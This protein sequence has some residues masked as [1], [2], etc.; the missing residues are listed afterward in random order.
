M[1]NNAKYFCSF[2]GSKWRA[3]R[4]NLCSTA[5]CCLKTL[6]TKG[7]DTAVQR[8]DI[9]AREVLITRLLMIG[10]VAC[11]C[12][13][14]SY[15]WWLAPRNTAHYGWSRVNRAMIQSWARSCTMIYR[16]LGACAYR[17]R[18]STRVTG[19]GNYS[20]D[21]HY[22]RISA[23]YMDSPSYKFVLYSSLLFE[24]LKEQIQQYRDVT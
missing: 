4:T 1:Y 18:D 17:C 23:Q 11:C 20:R 14:F 19:I 9:E 7:F 24:D 8:C 3:P 15:Y 22:A 10:V 5:I 13:Y 21:G 16:L 12:C 2:V 6:R